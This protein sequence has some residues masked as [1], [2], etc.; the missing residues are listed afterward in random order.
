MAT[1]IPDPLTA[2]DLQ[3][4]LGFA[5]GVT[6]T[7]NGA[8]VQNADGSEVWT[9]T[10]ASYTTPVDTEILRLQHATSR[11]VAPVVGMPPANVLTSIVGT[12]MTITAY[13]A[14]V[15]AGSAPNTT[16]VLSEDRMIEKLMAHL[17]VMRDTYM[18]GGDDPVFFERNGT[19]FD[20]RVGNVDP[21]TMNPDVLDTIVQYAAEK[22]ATDLNLTFASINGKTYT[23]PLPAGTTPIT[24]TNLEDV[25]VRINSGSQIIPVNN[26]EIGGVRPPITVT[27]SDP[28]KFTVTVLPDNTGIVITPVDGGDATVTWQ[29]E[30]SPST[31][32]FVVSINK[33]GIPMATLLGDAA[34]NAENG[35]AYTDAGYIN[36]NPASDQTVVQ[37]GDVLNTSVSGV[38]TLTWTFTNSFGSTVQTRV[39]TVHDTTAPVITLSGANPQTVTQ[40][41]AYTEAGGA[42]NGGEAVTISGTVDTATLGTYTVTYSATDAAGNTRTAT[43]SV[44]VTLAAGGYSP[45]FTSETDSNAVSPSGTSHSHVIDGITYYM[46]ESHPGNVMPSPGTALTAEK[47]AFV[48]AAETED[49]YYNDVLF[50]GGA[51]GDYAGSTY[52]APRTLTTLFGGAPQQLTF[53]DGTT[54]FI[55]SVTGGSLEDTENRY[56]ANHT[57]VYHLPKALLVLDGTQDV[58]SILFTTHS[59]DDGNATFVTAQSDISSYPSYVTNVYDV[60]A[61]W[62]SRVVRFKVIKVDADAVVVV[63]DTTAPVITVTGDNP[64][65]VSQG[66]T[67]TDAGAAADGGEAVTV[68][69][70]VDTATLGTYTLTYS[71]TDAAGNTGTA[72]RSVTVEAASVSVF[73]ARFINVGEHGLT[74]RVHIKVQGGDSGFDA[75]FHDYLNTN[76]GASDYENFATADYEAQI[77]SGRPNLVFESLGA[78]G[79]KVRRTGVAFSGFLQVLGTDWFDGDY[80]DLYNGEGQTNLFMS[81]KLVVQS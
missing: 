1:P 44:V 29:I 64:A 10:L 52:L 66:G 69:G 49:E 68:S 35:S 19:T 13:Q 58:N 32:G 18:V 33:G 51:S 45:L 50:D 78:V 53:N 48:Q 61:I 20:F 4:N 74:D 43:R 5:A 40:G 37:G 25:G 60:R 38:Y 3:A 63:Y 79:H 75:Q 59:Y 8:R 77:P 17:T 34:V 16:E 55:K 67:Y 14:G 26:P 7:Q 31:G 23:A 42:A 21:N 15:P 80:I 72:T 71:A 46:P 6:I 27:S 73:P 41:V 30:G 76:G 24:P 39:V 9:Y 47:L 28:S 56:V 81:L 11:Y 62:A 57:G 54:D 22:T 70:T 36:P 65:T 2:V 12:G